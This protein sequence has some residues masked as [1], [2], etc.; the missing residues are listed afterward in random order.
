MKPL[1]TQHCCCSV[2]QLYLTLCKPMD[3]SMSGFPV[4]H[5]LLEFAQ[6]HD[7]WVSVVIQP[8]HPLFSLSPL[9]SI[10]PSIRVFSMSWLFPLG[11]QR[12]G[13]SA[14]VLPMNIQCWFLL[15]LTGLI[16]LSNGLPRVFS[17]IT[18]QRHQFFYAQP[19][20]LSSSHIHI[21]LLEKP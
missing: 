14:S 18:I 21:W 13:A 19:F 3:C 7:H 8:F 17:S 10:F 20:L 2:A 6:T 1:V 11:G 4:L 5:Y 9:A 15:G 12:I 16:L